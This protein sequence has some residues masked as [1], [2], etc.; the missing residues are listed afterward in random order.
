MCHSYRLDIQL[1]VKGYF[2]YR[3][4]VIPPF[5]KLTFDSALDEFGKESTT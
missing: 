2:S 1:A 3:E 4:L 5:K